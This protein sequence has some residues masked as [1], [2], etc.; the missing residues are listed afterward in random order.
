MRLTHLREKLAHKHLDGLFVT[1]PQN[2]RYLSGFTSP[3]ASLIVT[4]TEALIATDF[5]YFV[6]AAEQCPDWELVQLKDKPEETLKE[7]L[8]ALAE[9]GLRR[10]GYEKTHLTV[11]RYHRLRRKVLPPGV[12][13]VATQGLVEELRMV[14]E[15]AELEI[16]RRA[17]RLGDEAYMAVAPRVRAGM[18]ERAVAWELEAWA[19]THGA[20]KASFDFIV[21]AGPNAAQPHA[22]PGDRPIQEGEPI[23][24]DMGVIVDG[25]CSDLTRTFCLGEPTEKFRAIWQIVRAAQE[26]AE[27]GIRAGMTGR[28]ADALARDVITAAGYG[29]NFGHGLGHGVGLA[30]HELPTANKRYRKPLPANSVI[31]IEPGIYIP[32]WGGVRLE[33]MVLVLPDGVEVLSTAPKTL[34]NE[35]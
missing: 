19:R 2:I 15:P 4:P 18:T 1:Q 22:E 26:K 25:Y 20:H 27:A 17:V 31:T 8:A 16:I 10:L 6:Q 30:V 32:D 9:K 28:R 11:E 7:R 3:D 35:L 14:K 29:E 23:T 5:R 34:T 12:H 33:D 13:F 24:I 21:A